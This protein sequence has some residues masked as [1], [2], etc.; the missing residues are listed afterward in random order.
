MKIVV[1]IFLYSTE[2]NV[3]CF[4]KALLKCKYTV[5]FDNHN[6]IKTKDFLYTIVNDSLHKLETYNWQ[7]QMIS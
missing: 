6:R 1:L 5:L 7:Y 2:T 3:S 4:C